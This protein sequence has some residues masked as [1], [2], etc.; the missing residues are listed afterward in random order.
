MKVF[1]Y[2]IKFSKGKS[3][4]IV[5]LVN[6]GIVKMHLNVKSVMQFSSVFLNLM[7]SH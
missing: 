2:F 1:I 6:L 7:I 3:Y 4:S 5:I